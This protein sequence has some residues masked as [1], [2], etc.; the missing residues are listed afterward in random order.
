[1]LESPNVSHMLEGSRDHVS[2]DK[3]VIWNDRSVHSE[4]KVSQMSGDQT[5]T[6][7]L[8]GWRVLIEKKELDRLWRS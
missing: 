1:M 7:G 8:S 4:Q 5:P 6:L 3:F 2:L